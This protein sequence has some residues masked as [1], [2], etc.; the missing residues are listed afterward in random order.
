MA[1]QVLSSPT[2][3]G[4][5][6]PSAAEAPTLSQ[7]LLSLRHVLSSGASINEAAEPGFN[8]LSSG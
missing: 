4:L 8:A 2:P 1:A 3:L 7:K 6:L 5:S